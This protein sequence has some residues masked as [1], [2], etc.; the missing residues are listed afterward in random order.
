[1]V[2]VSVH[3][4]VFVVCIVY[5]TVYNVQCTLYI[6]KC[7]TILYRVFRQASFY[8]FLRIF[9]TMRVA[10]NNMKR[11]VR[12]TSVYVVHCTTVYDVQCTSNSVYMYM[13][14]Y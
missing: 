12:D 13:V 11:S 14:S 9:Q 4:D 3:S 5:Y 10:L 6:V 8:D 2:Y 7:M 1:M